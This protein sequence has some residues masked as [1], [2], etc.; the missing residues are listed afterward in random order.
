MRPNF[1]FIGPDKSGSS[2]LHAILRQHPECFVPSSKDIYF[3]DRYFHRGMEWYLDHFRE[4]NAGHTAI[5]EL[6]HDY[7]FSPA[8]AERIRANLPGVRL[9]T[10][11]RKPIDRSFSQYLFMLRNGV[12]KAPFEQ[13]IDEFPNLLGNSFYARHLAV[14]FDAFDRDRIKVMFFE[15]LERD[16]RGFGREVFEFLGLRMIEQLPFETKV[17]TASRPRSEALA[18]LTHVAAVRARNLGLGRLVGML[19]QSPLRSLLYRPYEA[20]E[21]PRVAAETWARLSALFE[22]DIQRLEAMLERSLAEWRQPPE[23]T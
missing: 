4:A 21:R 15:N 14:Y 20:D 10:S 3:F 7:L 18:R 8:A 1:I 13:A 23:R 2:W 17:L 11:L 16:P 19:K 22:P 12:T 5:G 6:S 9:L